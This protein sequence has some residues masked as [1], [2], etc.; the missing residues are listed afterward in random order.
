[1]K[2]FDIQSQLQIQPVVKFV[3]LF[4]IAMMVV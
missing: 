3:P 4:M 2:K 1:M